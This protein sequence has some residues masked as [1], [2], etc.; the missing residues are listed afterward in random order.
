MGWCKG[1]GSVIHARVIVTVQ[2]DKV[3]IH[4]LRPDMLAGD[5][6]GLVWR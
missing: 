6:G 5:E 3:E 1:V 4:E 2:L